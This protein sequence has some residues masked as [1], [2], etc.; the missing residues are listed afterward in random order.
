VG[1]DI[2]GSKKK[3]NKVKNIPASKTVIPITLI[4]PPFLFFDE[5]I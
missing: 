5:V 2:S 1:V 4:N 3:V